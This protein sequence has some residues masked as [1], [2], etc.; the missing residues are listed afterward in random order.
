[1][2]DNT[3]RVPQGRD[4]SVGT[5]KSVGGHREEVIVG[6]LKSGSEALLDKS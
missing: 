5:L 6:T 1:M 2:R 3:G 4:E